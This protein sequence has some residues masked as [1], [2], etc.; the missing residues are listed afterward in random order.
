M[1]IIIYIYA[2]IYFWNFQLTFSQYGSPLS[3]GFARIGIYR[4]AFEHTRHCF[5]LHDDITGL[6]LIEQKRKHRFLSVH[7]LNHTRINQMTR[8]WFQ[9]FFM[10]TPI[11]G[12]W[13]HFGSYFS[14]G[15]VQPPTSQ[16][17][18]ISK[19]VVSNTSFSYRWYF[20]NRILVVE[21]AMAPPSRSLSPLPAL[22]SWMKTHLS[23]EKNPGWLGYIGDEMLPN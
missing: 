17:Q 19:N 15:L 3:V 5:F 2:C 22:E 18:L 13:T 1:Y 20:G 7:E 12:R 14:T 9:I 8:W 11:W 10:F 4:P 23:N 21:H 6:S 16:P